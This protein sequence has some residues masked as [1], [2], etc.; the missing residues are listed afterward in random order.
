MDIGIIGTGKMGESL[1]RG[2]IEE[3]GAGGVIANDHDKR[4]LSILQEELGFRI[5]TNEMI[6]KAQTVIIAVKPQDFPAL[7]TG[8]RGEGIFISIMAGVSLGRL[9]R[10]LHSSRVVRVM[11]NL[12]CTVKEATMAYACG[13]GIENN[14]RKIVAG[15]L[16]LFGPAIELDEDLMDPVTALSGSGPAFVARFVQ[17]MTDA[18]ISQG[19]GKD[20]A[21]ILT[22]QVIRGTLRVLK[23]K[24]TSPNDLILSVSSKGGTTVAGLSAMD[25]YAFEKTIAETIT[26]AT[27]RSRE[28]GK[29]G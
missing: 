5:G 19:L 28:L 11:A 27:M 26:R 13:K 4:K 15:L 3:Y 17:A 9:E 23:E 16:K 22:T 12:C 7:A 14:E 20:E 1:L 6:A 8:M 2:V 25:E 29:N 10:E 18:G 21:Y 24:G